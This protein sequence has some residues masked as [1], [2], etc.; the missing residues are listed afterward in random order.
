MPRN[1]KIATIILVVVTILIG[2]TTILPPPGTPG[3]L[4]EVSTYIRKSTQLVVTLCEEEQA[5]APKP[6]PI[7]PGGNELA[8]EEADTIIAALNLLCSSVVKVNAEVPKSN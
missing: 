5:I 2:L 7:E 4:G 3:T 6:L 8:Q 1:K